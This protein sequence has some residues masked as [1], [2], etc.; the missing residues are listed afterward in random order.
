MVTLTKVQRA[1]LF[2]KFDGRCAYCGGDLPERGWHADHVEPVYR[3]YKMV[4]TDDHR[5]SYKFVQTGECY[6]PEN[7]HAENFMPS[8]RACNIDKSTLTLEDW[9][10]S[11]ERKVQV[12]RKNYSAYRHA[13]R[14][15]LVAEVKAKVIFHFE[16]LPIVPL[17]VLSI[18]AIR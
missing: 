15:G 3:K 8:C 9:R 11:L 13:E 2:A 17:P 7:D 4:R 12:L 16:Q 1:Q 10:K 18:A 6:A 5:H 14:F